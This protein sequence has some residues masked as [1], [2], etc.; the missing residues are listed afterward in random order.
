MR[1]APLA[2]PLQLESSTLRGWPTLPS[3][4]TSAEEAAVLAAVDDADRRVVGVGLL[5]EPLDGEVEPHH[6]EGADR[7]PVADDD[8]RRVGVAVERPEELVDALGDVGPALAARVAEVELAHDRREPL[9]AVDP[10]RIALDALL[11][12]EAVEEAVLLLADE[13]ALADGGLDP[14]GDR[15]GRLAAEDVGARPNHGIAPAL[16]LELL[17]EPLAREDG[18]VEAAR[19][20]P[21]RVVA[22]LVRD[23]IHVGLGLAVAD[24]VD[25]V[26]L[27]RHCG[28]SGI[29]TSAIATQPSSNWTSFESPSS[30]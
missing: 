30:S 21:D 5:L 1:T 11:V 8:H 6:E 7:D 18:L 24:E 12:R 9:L 17:L 19:R 15:G 23:R 3:R 27:R 29:T 13:D 20:Q 16:L 25:R 10:L 28:G 22:L 14:L 2:L 4:A 26:E